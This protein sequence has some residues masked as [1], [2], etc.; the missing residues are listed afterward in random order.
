MKNIFLVTLLFGISTIGQSLDKSFIV[1][2]KI[3][4]GAREVGEY[5]FVEYSVKS[6]DGKL[7]Y[8]IVDKVDYDIPYSKLEV[9]EDGSSV[10]INAVYGT[11]TFISNNGTKN[12]SVNV[13]KNFEVEYERNILSV[14][15]SNSLLILIHEPN[16][17]Y[18]ILQIY[19]EKG[20][21]ESEYTVP[22]TNIN[23]IAYSKTL[24]QIYLSYTTWNNLGEF[25]KKLALLNSGGEILKTIS[26]NFEKGFF[27]ENNQFV[28]LS[29]KSIISINTLELELSYD[30]KA[31]E[32]NIFIDISDDN[33]AII[34]AQ[35]EYPKLVNGKWYY[36]NPTIIKLDSTG[37]TLSKINLTTDLFCEYEFQKSEGSMKFVAGTK[38]FLV[39]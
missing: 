31:N 27:T 23:G 8:Q 39:E 32:N 21:V 14:I 38:R 16:K 24:S 34:V 11:L 20:S 2:E 29:N 13:I 5:N 12:K 4:G 19:N 37:S 30:I 26:A 25:T 28:G 22:I 18:S 1:E 17:N 15:D 10:L 3:N 35:A 36:K 7:L 6:N 9:F 33:G